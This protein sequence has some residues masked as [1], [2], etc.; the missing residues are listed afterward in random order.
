MVNT[1]KSSKESKGDQD[2]QTR[3]SNTSIKAFER[4]SKVLSRSPMKLDSSFEVDVQLPM[5]I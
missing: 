2:M 5:L 1:L 4:Q 3:K